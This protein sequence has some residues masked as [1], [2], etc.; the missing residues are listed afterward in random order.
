MVILLRLERSPHFLVFNYLR[1]RN[2]KIL[3]L[4]NSGYTLSR[5]TYTASSLTG[6]S[7]F[8]YELSYCNLVAVTQTQAIWWSLILLSL[9][10]KSIKKIWMGKQ[11]KKCN[12]CWNFN[13]LG[14][15][16]SLISADWNK[17][18]PPT[19]RYVSYIWLK[20]WKFWNPWSQSL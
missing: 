15:W 18:N 12:I 3:L 14:S 17:I 2:R 10:D 5:G 16:S 6:I 1:I 19:N 8:R 13:G 11:V 20:M 4:S 9:Y 7:V